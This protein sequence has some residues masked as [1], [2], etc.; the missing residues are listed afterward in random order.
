MLLDDDCRPG[1]CRPEHDPPR[2]GRPGFARGQPALHRD[3]AADGIDDAG[4]LEEQSSVGAL[5]MRPCCS[6]GS[7]S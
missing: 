6:A 1:V 5:T 7:I 3:A 4:E 2:F